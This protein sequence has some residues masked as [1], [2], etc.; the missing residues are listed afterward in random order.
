[1]LAAYYHNFS[2]HN[3]KKLANMSGLLY[4]P[5]KIKDLQIQF[6]TGA[7]YCTLKHLTTG[8]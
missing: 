7:F 5:L 2:M 8:R 3:I 6:K 4:N 1:M